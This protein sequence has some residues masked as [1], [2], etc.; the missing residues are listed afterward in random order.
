MKIKISELR[1]ISKHL[2]EYLIRS[3]RKEI[4][5]DEDYY[6]YVKDDV[7]YNPDDEPTDLSLGQ[8]SDDLVELRKIKTGESPPHW[9]RVMLAVFYSQNYR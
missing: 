6:W 5:F 4:E 9:V 1:T 8:L 2:F 3:G 7:A